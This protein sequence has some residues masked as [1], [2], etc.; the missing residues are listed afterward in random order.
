MDAEG[1]V[2][3]SVT[4]VAANMSTISEINMK[5]NSVYVHSNQSGWVTISTTPRVYNLLS[6]D[7]RGESEFLA[8]ANVKAGTYDQV[9][10]VVDSVAIKT[11]A[12]E[13]KVAKL[14]SGELKINTVL[15]VNA[16]T[17][18]SINF[19]FLADKSLHTA[20]DG[21][22]IFA[23]VVKTETKSN[24]SVS[25]NASNVVTI[26]GGRI[27]NT[28]TVGMDIDGSIEVNFQIDSKQKLDLDASGVIKLNGL[29]N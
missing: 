28:N 17:T 2:V 29:L 24:A 8:E 7:A 16:N 26:T 5:V 18:S 6:L 19:D 22:Y 21:N 23:P 14:P 4:D 13:T 9:R 20:S 15:V 11:K 27:D 1:R 10:L 12:G 3:F 25:V